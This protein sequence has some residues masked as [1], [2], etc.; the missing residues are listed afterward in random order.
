MKAY[1]RLVL[2]LNL[3]LAVDGI[4]LNWC[5]QNAL[6]EL[7]SEDLVIAKIAEPDLTAVNFNYLFR[8]R[9]GE[10]DRGHIEVFPKFWNLKLY[11]QMSGKITRTLCLIVP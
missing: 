5:E 4:I 6:R 7:M 1:R 8:D 2:H 10:V 9:M 11:D 3:I